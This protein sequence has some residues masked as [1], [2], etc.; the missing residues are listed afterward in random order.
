[1][2]CKTDKIYTTETKII[3]EVCQKQ[4]WGGTGIYK[5][6]LKHTTLYSSYSTKQIKMQIADILH[7]TS[8]K[9]KPII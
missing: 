7:D 8:L 3:P 6:T 9:G 4:K 5:N 1:M 2:A